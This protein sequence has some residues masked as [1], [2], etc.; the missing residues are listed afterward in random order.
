MTDNRNSDLIAGTSPTFVAPLN[1]EIL[2]KAD[3]SPQ[4]IAL[5]SSDEAR[6]F[7]AASDAIAFEALP[8]ALVR[9]GGHQLLLHLAVSDS[10]ELSRRKLRF[11]CGI[12]VALTQVPSRILKP[13]IAKAYFGSE[14]RLKSYIAPI[15]ASESSGARVS[16]L[17]TAGGCFKPPKGDAARFITALLEFAA[18]RGVS[19]LHLSPE[20]KSVVIRMRID[21][22]LCGLEKDPYDRSFHDQVI[23]RLKVLSGLDLTNRRLPQD[24]AFRYSFGDLTKSARLSTLPTLHGE[25][26]VIRLLENQDILSLNQIGLEPSTAELIRA[27][28]ERTEGLIL[29]TGPTGSGKTTTMYS[30]ARELERRSYNVVTV[31]DPVESPL[32]GLV[33]V[34]V[35]TEQGLDY[36]RA[37]RSV[38]RH[39]PDALLI[40]EM[41]DS[42]S[43]S[44]AL[45]AASTGHLT[46]SSL[47]VG[48]ALHAIGRL[49]VLG[50][51]RERTV[52][53]LL[54]IL[55]QRL[56]RKLCDA[57][58]IVDQ[59]SAGSKLKEVYTAVG[60]QLCAGSGYRGR[61]L[62]TEAL[63]LREQRAKDACFRAKT[64]GELLDMLPIGASIPWTHSLQHH[65]T[66]GDIS[67][68]QVERFV[69]A[70]MEL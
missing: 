17:S 70:E 60:C 65:L 55:N 42:L 63:D 48:S 29:L 38:L 11:L 43:A 22:D 9:G 35:C 20:A 53:P 67:L 33:Q 62:I 37:I 5:S 36:P 19:D 2:T 49:E 23:T 18:A 51:G 13:A 64:L 52:P 54:V 39:D 10:S 46:L 69:G 4:D 27:A 66:R 30:L 68:L 8:L 25:S 57:C 24:G 44:I 16:D 28:L 47:H 40:G 1:H 15:A 7:L 14:Q 31:E 50:V 34:Q 41:R 12:N 26:A 56:L 59:S 58:K 6:A 21:G 32:P 45:D 61:V 3:L